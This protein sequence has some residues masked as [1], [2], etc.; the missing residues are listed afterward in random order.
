MRE[1]VLHEVIHCL[2]D[3]QSTGSGGDKALIP[4]EDEERFVRAFSPLLLDTLRRN[5]AL[6]T[7]LLAAE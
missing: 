1:T 4:E 7:Y 5:K 3:L 6:T 2:L